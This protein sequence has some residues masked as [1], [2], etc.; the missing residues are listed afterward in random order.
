[1]QLAHGWLAVAAVEPA[2]PCP[3][4]QPRQGC[5][6]PSRPCPFP[7]RGSQLSRGL[8][9]R[10]P[11]R[12][13][14]YFWSAALPFPCT[15]R[16][17]GMIGLPL[18]ID[19]P[20]PI[21]RLSMVIRPVPPP[22]ARIVRHRVFAESSSL[23][24]GSIGRWCFSSLAHLPPTGFGLSPI[25]GSTLHE[26]SLFLSRDGRVTRAWRWDW[27]EASCSFHKS[28]GGLGS[29]SVWLRRDD[30]VTRQSTPAASL[31][32]AHG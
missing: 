7:P 24:K 26:W 30:P 15:A 20:G 29:R 10:S 22:S 17:A 16:I 11:P 28:T 1:M 21:Y 12:A 23:G 6:P 18:L 8:R 31:Q 5:F 4:S 9:P 3:I 32:P 25:I 14:P 2:G 19:V 27:P 13:G